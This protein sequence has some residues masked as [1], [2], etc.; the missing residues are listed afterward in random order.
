MYVCTPP[1][2]PTL[3]WGS[4]TGGQECWARLAKARGRA[5]FCLL[6]VGP[7]SRTGPH[8]LEDLPGRFQRLLCKPSRRLFPQAA[9]SAPKSGGKALWSGPLSGPLALSLGTS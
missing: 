5:G 3:S 1:L 6:P 7:L 9:R 4:T 2:Q 8:P